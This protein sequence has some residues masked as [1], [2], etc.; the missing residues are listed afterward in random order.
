MTSLDPRSAFQPLLEAQLHNATELSRQ[1]ASAASR[2]NELHLQVA[3][4]LLQDTIEATRSLLFVTDPLQLGA[5]AVEAS[6]PL[7]QHLGGYQRQLMDILGG[8]Q[9]E[10]A[11]GMGSVLPAA[12]QATEAL[13]L[14]ISRNV[15][16]GA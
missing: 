3:Q 9:G 4:Q 7:M 12:N 11:R 10:F 1:A 14:L 15:I 6:G 8:A 5:G 2:L 16:S 13:A